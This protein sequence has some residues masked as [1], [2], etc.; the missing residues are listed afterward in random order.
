MA[1]REGREARVARRIEVRILVV[2]EG[3]VGM[4]L[5][6]VRCGLAGFGW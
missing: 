1:K 6:W 3:V 2:R 4:G 5:G